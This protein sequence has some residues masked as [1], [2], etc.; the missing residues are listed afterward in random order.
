MRKSLY[1]ILLIVISALS[2]QAQPDQWQ[3]LFNGK[4]LT[5]WK[6]VGPG[7]DTVENGLIQDPW[8]HGL[9]LLDGRKIGKLCHSRGVQDAR[10]K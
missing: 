3:Q 9:A 10:P 5:G 7:G 4:D 1:V 6:H 8:W 2:L